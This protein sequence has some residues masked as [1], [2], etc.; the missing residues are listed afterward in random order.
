MVSS[1]GPIEAI[2]PTRSRLRS[3]QVFQQ[4]L[5]PGG[6]FD[7]SRACPMARELAFVSESSETHAAATCIPIARQDA[8]PNCSQKALKPCECASLRDMSRNLTRHSEATQ[9]RSRGQFFVSAIQSHKQSTPTS[10]QSLEP[11]CKT[12]S[13]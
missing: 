13:L 1:R 7:M 8:I 5:R 4:P 6:S 2:V 9:Q 11:P 3:K 12:I 10:L